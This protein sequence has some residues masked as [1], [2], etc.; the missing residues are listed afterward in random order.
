LNLDTMFDD[1][2]APSYPIVTGVSKSLDLDA[3]QII[4]EMKLEYN[5]V[6]E[7]QRQSREQKLEFSTSPICLTSIADVHLG[8]NGV[9]IQRLFDETEIVLNT[10]NMWINFVGDLVENQIL[11]K[12]MHVRFGGELSPDKE[13]FVLKEYLKFAAPKILSLVPGNHENWVT[14]LTGIPF[15]S[16]VARQIKPQVLLNA[17]DSRITVRVGSAEHVIRSRHKWR[18]TSKYNVTHGIED[19]SRLDA[20]FDIGV[21]AHTH[22]GGYSRDFNARGKHGIALICGTYKDVDEY[23]ESSGFPEPN[24]STAVS[25]IIWDDGRML[26]VNNL[27][28]AS[29]IMRGYH[30]G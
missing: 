27:K 26:G 8:H 16:E 21:G 30:V 1:E 17:F 12:L 2:D 11:A 10:P 3:K 18:Y 25:V 7:I 22:V 14:I 5:R 24:G 28:T 29:E 9:N 23:K 13:W 20:D 4:Q 6:K 15:F 19:M